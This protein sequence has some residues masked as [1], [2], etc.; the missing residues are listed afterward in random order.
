MFLLAEV[1]LLLFLRSFY[2]H[3]LQIL[4]FNLVVLIADR[5]ETA[6]YLVK[7]GANVAVYDSSGLSALSLM[8]E[9]MPPVAQKALNQYHQTDRANRKQYFYLSLLEADLTGNICK[10]AKSPLEV[11]FF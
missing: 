11:N 9:K 8:I 6:K 5:S 1:N 4:K 7:V 3:I 10:V 2:F